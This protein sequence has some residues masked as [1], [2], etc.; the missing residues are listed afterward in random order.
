MNTM[1]RD[2]MIKERNDITWSIGFQT[3]RLLTPFVSIFS[4]VARWLYLDEEIK[5]ATPKPQM[6]KEEGV[7]VQVDLSEGATKDA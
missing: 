6:V 4:G 7:K 2:D 5:K 1:K 3:T